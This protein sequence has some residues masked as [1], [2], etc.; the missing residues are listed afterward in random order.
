MRKSRIGLVAAVVVVVLL[1][2]T[3]A[4][5]YPAYLKTFMDTY[6]V[7]PDSALGK[8]SCAVC[9]VA[10]DK[11]NQWNPYGQDLKK[12]LAG[13]KVTKAALAKIEKLDSD[14]DG[15]SNIDEIKAGTLPGDPKSK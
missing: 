15:V 8:A 6:K 13:G 12:V 5:A 2:S 14:K 4:W 3:I 1:V 11:T 9:H 10:K 7:K